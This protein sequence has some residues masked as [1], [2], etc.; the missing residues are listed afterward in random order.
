MIGQNFG[1][2]FTPSSIFD[3]TNPDKN[4]PGELSNNPVEKVQEPVTINQQTPDGSEIVQVDQP[5]DHTIIQPVSE[6]YS[7]NAPMVLPVAPPVYDTI[8]E[9]VPASVPNTTFPAPL[10]DRGESELL[11][12]RWSEIQGKFVDEP[13]TAVQE[14]DK[15]VSEVVEKITEMFAN[16]HSTL[17]SQWKQG[18]D[19]STEELRK[20]LQHYRSFFNRL[21]V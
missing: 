6:A 5:L 8:S 13:R 11:R 2:H 17:E 16:E 7:Y 14:A 4:N 3:E 21:V 9:S 10:L 12:K 1:E 19:V 15:L 20:A 18:N